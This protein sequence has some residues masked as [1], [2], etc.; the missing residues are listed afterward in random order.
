MTWSTRMRRRGVLTVAAL[1]LV[2][3]LAL[4][5]CGGRAAPNVTGNGAGGSQTTTGQHGEV[6]LRGLRNG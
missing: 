6:Y 3:V 2:L 4:S 5:A 1:A